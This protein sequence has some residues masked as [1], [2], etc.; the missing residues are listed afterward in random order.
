MGVCS[1]RVEAIPNVWC[2][3]IFV[4]AHIDMSLLVAGAV[5]CAG[6][7]VWKCNFRGRRRES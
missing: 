5:L 1:E 3:A 2:G 7:Q 6:F 4:E